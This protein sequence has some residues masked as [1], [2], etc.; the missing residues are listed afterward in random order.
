MWK[1]DFPAH[2]TMFGFV[3]GYHRRFWQGSPDHR[4]TAEALGRVVTLVSTANMLRFEDD[5]AHLENDSVTWGRLYKVPDEHIEGTLTQLDNREQA[6]Y[7]RCMVDVHCHDGSVRRALVYIATPENA[8]FLG[9]APL[10]IVAQQIATRCGP[11]GPNIEYFEKLCESMRALGVHDPHLVALE[12]AVRKFASQQLNG[13]SEPQ[14]TITL[15]R[16]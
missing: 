9:P 4:G 2:D 13:A 8:D 16:M 10:D 1:T 12:D 14:Q 15:T 6:G 11:S 5:H 3:K 7:E